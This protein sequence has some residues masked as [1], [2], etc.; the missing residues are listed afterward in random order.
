MEEGRWLDAKPVLAPVQFGAMCSLFVSGTSRGHICADA[1]A[2]EPLPQ[3]SATVGLNSR[4]SAPK[5]QPD[6]HVLYLL[7]P[8]DHGRR[9]AFH[10][11]RACASTH[12]YS[13]RRTV[14]PDDAN[15]RVKAQVRNL[16]VFVTVSLSKDR[17]GTGRTCE[18]CGE[19][20]PAAELSLIG[21][22]EWLD[23][24]AL[25]LGYG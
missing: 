13:V 9:K 4:H 24:G 3:V 6:A 10:V 23:Q 25:M 18:W 17:P 16:A 2:V 1:C 12:H 21:L 19:S 5:W 15:H 11:K 14:L 7:R 8:V 22:L 20:T